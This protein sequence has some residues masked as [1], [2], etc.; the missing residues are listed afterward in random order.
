M[1]LNKC[2]WCGLMAPGQVLAALKDAPQIDRILCG[3]CMR[4]L[5]FEI[6]ESDPEV[7]ATQKKYSALV[8]AAIH[9]L[10]DQRL[11]H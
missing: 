7:Q 5:E 1:T 8:T 9:R 2:E 4:T 10:L 6:W 11:S 3:Q